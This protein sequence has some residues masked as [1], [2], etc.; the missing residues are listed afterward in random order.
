MGEDTLGWTVVI[1]GVSGPGIHGYQTTAYCYSRL[2]DEKATSRNAGYTTMSTTVNDERPTQHRYN[3]KYRVTVSANAI[4]RTQAALHQHTQC[5]AIALCST[6][7]L[8]SHES[9]ILEYS[10]AGRAYMGRGVHSERYI[11]TTMP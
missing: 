2:S 3:F 1:D 11:C 7:T 5:N 10:A 4:D 8:A 9:C 6:T